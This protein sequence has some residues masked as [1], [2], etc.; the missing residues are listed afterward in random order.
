M[1]R[2]LVTGA[3]GMLGSEVVQALRGGWDVVEADLAEFDVADAEA[4]LSAIGDVSPELVVNCAAYTDVDGAETHTEEAFAV[5]ASG[6][7]SV[8]RAAAAVNA[9]LVHVSTD[10]VFDGRSR[11][12]YTEDDEPNPL[13]VYGETKLAGEREVEA[14]G[15][16]SLIVRTAWLYGRGGKNFVDTILRLAGTDETL[17][18][19][20]DQRGTPTSARD[21]AVIIKELA[22]GR[23]DG[24]VNA[25]NTGAASWYEFALE[26]LRVS[27]H[28][29][30]D[31]EPIATS[32][33]PRPAVRPRS[34]VLSLKRLEALL[35]WTPRPWKE[36]LAEYLLER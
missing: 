4:T 9:F 19:V 21:L 14:S 29:S 17:R 12:P 34:S 15:A 16:D 22:A 32:A 10:Y 3:A 18:I 5:N 13:N 35:G 25:T 6:A 33:Y 31:I 20:D 28:T 1:R 27:G 26:I 23:P 30:A 7:G 36:A 24:M 8:A 11:E 2:A